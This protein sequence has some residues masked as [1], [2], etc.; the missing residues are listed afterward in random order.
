MS[1]LLIVLLTIAIVWWC[2]FLMGMVRGAPREW[3]FGVFQDVP[4]QSVYSTRTAEPAITPKHWQFFDPKTVPPQMPKLPEAKRSP[5]LS[6]LPVPP[7]GA[8][9]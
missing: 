8:G 1:W 6:E 2:M 5:K 3:D 9:P 4:A 7:G